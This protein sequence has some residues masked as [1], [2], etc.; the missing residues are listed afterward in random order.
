MN[1]EV[2]YNTDKPQKYASDKKLESKLL[3]YFDKI[4]YCQTKFWQ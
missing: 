1:C 4:L 2:T 3:F